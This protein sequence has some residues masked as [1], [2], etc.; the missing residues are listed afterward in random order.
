M[1]LAPVEE[2]SSQEAVR[3]YGSEGTMPSIATFGRVY[4]RLG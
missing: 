2:R 1:S 4:R 3:I